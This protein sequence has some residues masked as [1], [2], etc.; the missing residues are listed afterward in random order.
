ME[1]QLM[2]MNL[3]GKKCDWLSVNV[4]SGETSVACCQIERWWGPWMTLLWNRVLFHV[5]TP[6]GGLRLTFEG[7][8]SLCH[9]CLQMFLV[10]RSSQP[11][12]GRTLTPHLLAFTH[13]PT[14]PWD[15][16]ALRSGKAQ[17]QGFKT[18]NC[19]NQKSCQTILPIFWQTAQILL[20]WHGTAHLTITCNEETNLF[21]RPTRP[22]TLLQYYLVSCFKSFNK[23]HTSG[24]H[25]PSDMCTQRGLH[26]GMFS[27][28]FRNDSFFSNTRQIKV[29][30]SWAL[31]FSED[32]RFYGNSWL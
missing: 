7:R 29:A 6:V 18:C 3:Q 19:Q 15:S 13:C 28:R 12:T 24:T 23:F 31:C 17:P 1:I 22:P 16:Q 26:I 2:G 21:A 8:T 30:F 27:R 10:T 14:H 4:L 25:S 11:G 20:C 5:K 9:I 32:F